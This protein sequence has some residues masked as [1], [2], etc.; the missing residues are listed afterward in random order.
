MAETKRVSDQYKISAPSIVIDGNLTVLGSTTSVETINSTIEDNIITLNQGESG[1]GVTRGAAGIEV[2]RGSSDNA[3]F[4]FNETDDVW[5]AKVGTT[6][7]VLRS[8]DPTSDNDVATKSYVDSNVG[9]V[10]PAGSI[11]SIQYNDGSGFGG[12]ND[13][14]WNGSSII[15]GNRLVLGAYDI[16]VL[17]T[18]ENLILS[19]NGSGK[20]Y[21]KNVLKLENEISDPL[22]EADSNLVYSKIP[23]NAGSGIYFTNTST[24]GELV[25]KSK[26]I[27]FGLI[28]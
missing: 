17:T 11:G 9:A 28:F 6:F 20:I 13:L 27:L 15:I 12:T 26:A 19:A 1:L 7:S 2:D 23:G 4:L 25:S 10:S 8:A 24:S 14:L 21:L 18:D 5:E 3:N 22:S 16:T